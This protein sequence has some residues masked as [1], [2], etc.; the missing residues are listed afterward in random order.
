MDDPDL[1]ATIKG[2]SPGQRVFSRYTLTRILGRGG[3]GVVWLAR[4]EELG[5]DTA[6]KF[7]PEVVAT[8]RAAIDDMKREVRRAIDLAHPHIVKIHDFVTDGRTAAVS[9]EYVA[10][11]TL[12][13]LRVDEPA[14]CFSHVRLQ[15]WVRQLADALDYAHR[16][17]EVV[18]RDLKPANLMID[19]RGRLKVLDFGIAA[20]ISDSV[21]RV[22]KQAGASGTPVY[23]SPQQ[24]MGE[25]PAVT[26]DLYS[27]GATLHELL[28]GKPPF[29]SGNIVLQVQSKPAPSVAERRKEYGAALEALPAAW[30]ETIAALLAKDPK[31]R[32]QSAA[33][34]LD[35]LGLGP[36]G[37]PVT[38][39]VPTT[40]AAAAPAAP[41][42]AP[43]A[44]A[45]ASVSNGPRFAVKLA[46]VAGLGAAD[47][48]AFAVSW[49][50]SN[51]LTAVALFVH[52]IGL[53]LLVLGRRAGWALLTLGALITCWTAWP[54]Y[55]ENG[56]APYLI[57]SVARLVLCGLG[58]WWWSRTEPAFGRLSAGGR[59]GCLI[60]WIATALGGPLAWE[61]L[62]QAWASLFP[63]GLFSW[64]MPPAQAITSSDIWGIASTVLL[65]ALLVLRKRD[66]WLILAIGE[67]TALAL[68]PW[69]SGLIAGAAIA[70]V[71]AAWGWIEW[72]PKPGRSDAGGGHA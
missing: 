67:I 3:M 42:P 19:A 23:M 49:G 59:L 72:K 55:I 7:L 8:D 6:L 66:A 38:T 57:R 9:M 27:L 60:A 28:A 11:S 46:A 2:F 24:M 52:T 14:R 32:P 25:K 50:A 15:E 64:S 13:S 39:S 62:S 43:A 65:N 63:G 30:E 44:V 22:S 35:R 26:D 29:H 47:G 45:T 51:P 31:D 33:E 53:G 69:N 18:H 12:S 71:L 41:P 37:G 34:V 20:S 10:G 68:F 58:W 5:R 56:H 4:D 40:P 1:G 54:L 16:D 70:L 21:S 17:A 48:L 36:G 61:A